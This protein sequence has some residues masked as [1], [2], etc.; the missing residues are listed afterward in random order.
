[1]INLVAIIRLLLTPITAIILIIYVIVVVLMCILLG[2]ED[3]RDVL[4]SIFNVEAR[5]NN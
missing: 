5:K 2:K 1:M 3:A 4:V